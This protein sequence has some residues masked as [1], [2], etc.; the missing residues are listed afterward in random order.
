LT[1]QD[2]F[3]IL[4]FIKKC[5]PDS[6][7][8]TQLR[9]LTR[10]ISVPMPFALSS[11]VLPHSSLLYLIPPPRYQEKLYGRL[12]P[13]P[14]DAISRSYIRFL[15]S[16]ETSFPNLRYKCSSSILGP[17]DGSTLLK[18]TE[19]TITMTARATRGVAVELTP[20]ARPR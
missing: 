17:F 9:R 10:S 12:L 2:F 8:G 18:R 5:D 6:K 20:P 19:S 1:A 14:I 3:S 13:L 11:F 7:V 15:R 16:S 4:F